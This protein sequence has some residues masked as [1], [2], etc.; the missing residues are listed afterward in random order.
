VAKPDRLPVFDATVRRRGR[1]W[2]WFVSTVEA[3][4]VMSGSESR[5][6]AAKYQA[7]KAIFLLLSAAPYRSIRPKDL[8]IK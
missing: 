1:G 7:N 3:E 5:R 2:R 6:S 8:Q 4:I